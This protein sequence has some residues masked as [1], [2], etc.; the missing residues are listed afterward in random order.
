M[1]LTRYTLFKD[2]VAVKYDVVFYE[3]LAYNN[4]NQLWRCENAK[5]QTG[6]RFK[7]L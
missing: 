6:L 1:T 7:K 5:Y 3:V 4:N 2:W